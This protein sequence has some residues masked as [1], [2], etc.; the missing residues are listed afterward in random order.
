M[1]E[2]IIRILIIIILVVNLVLGIYDML[3]HDQEFWES[4]EV[5]GREL[6]G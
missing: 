2:R 4:V 3:L 6:N 5:L 1:K